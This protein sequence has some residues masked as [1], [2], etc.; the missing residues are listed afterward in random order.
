VDTVDTVDTTAT[1]VVAVSLSWHPTCRSRQL[2][3]RRMLPIFFFVVVVVEVEAEADGGGGSSGCPRC[4]RCPR[5]P[6]PPIDHTP[7]LL[8]HARVRKREHGRLRALRAPR[9]HVRALRAPRVHVRAYG[10][11]RLGQPPAKKS[12]TPR[13]SHPH[14]ATHRRAHRGEQGITTRCRR[15]Y[16]C[17]RFEQAPRPTPRPCAA[18]ASSSLEE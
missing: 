18:A 15:F 5:L 13:P 11:S 6:A 4:P 1:S 12:W 9:V 16:N 17:C 10:T 14:P 2:H 3:T 7:S 8:I